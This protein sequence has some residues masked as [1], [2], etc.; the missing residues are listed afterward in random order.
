MKPHGL[1]QFIVGERRDKIDALADEALR[2]H[3][4]EALQDS[5]AAK[6]DRST[7]ILRRTYSPSDGV[8]DEV[9]GCPFW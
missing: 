1:G 4:V 3:G 2:L 7:D 9:R 5:R 6:S 8:S